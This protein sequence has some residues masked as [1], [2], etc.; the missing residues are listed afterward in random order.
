MA[1][2][3]APTLA[4]TQ[5]PTQMPTEPLAPT[6]APT[7]APGGK[8]GSCAGCLRSSGECYTDVDASYCGHWSANLWCGGCS[9]LQRSTSEV[10]RHLNFLGA[11]LIQRSSWV[12]HIESADDEL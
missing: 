1:P 4:P 8:C 3:Q 6:Q 9:L 12:E 2:T 11:A 10:K 7:Q 5:A